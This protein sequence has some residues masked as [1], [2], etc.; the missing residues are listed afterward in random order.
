M[1][2]VIALSL[3]AGTV[4]F[5]QQNPGDPDEPQRRFGVGPKLKTF[6]Q[7]TAK[8]ALASAIDAIEKGD[9]PYLLA[10]LLDPGFVDF[11]V[12]DRSK[13][14]EATIEVELARVRDLQTSNPDRYRPED[15]VP[16]DRAKFAA[17]VA[18]RSRDRAFRQLVSDMQEKL[19]DDPQAFKDLKT[20]LREGTFEDIATGAKVSHPDVKNRALF[21]SKIGERWFL[22]NRHEDAP[23]PKMPGM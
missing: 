7:Q 20:L 15:R 9:V 11:R 13:Q 23:P 8:K 17:L 16:T 19:R 1:R 2:L 5:A 18:E 12:D 3:C 6:P 14:Y 10:H 22:E 21:L 4:A